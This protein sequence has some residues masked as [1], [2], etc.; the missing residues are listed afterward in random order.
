MKKSKIVIILISSII[1]LLC[2]IF[3]ILSM[4]GTNEDLLERTA[5]I[6]M[7]D[8]DISS[9]I[10]GRIEWIN[11][12]EGDIIYEGQKLFKLT[13]R[14]ISAKVEQA[15][16]AV[17]SAQAQ[18]SM[19]NNGARPEQI[20]MA[21][22]NYIAA[23]SQYDLAKKTYDRMKKLHDD[24]LI[25]DQDLDVIA[26]K[27]YAA[28]AQMDASSSQY[29]MAQKGSRTEE[30][31]MAQGQ[32]YRAK[33]SLEEA[34][35]YFDE[36]VVKSL[37]NGI[38]YKRYVDKGELVATGYPVLSVI[39]TNDV[40]AEL[41]LPAKELESIKIG[42][43]LDG[44][45]YGLGTTE[46]FKVVSFAQMGEYSNWRSTNEKATFDTHSFTVKLKPLNKSIPS[47]RPGM[48]VSFKIKII[49]R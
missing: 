44:R 39:D 9:K 20:E 34:K 36:S 7:R 48:S 25:S 32:F 38:V 26:Q 35:S 45:I 5:T 4:N 3:T 43:V 10:P 21:E 27:L 17:E 24:K 12:D 31:Q 29:Q 28:S 8:Y 19:A 40:W 46:K 1:I 49:G 16:G 15:Q 22:K 30:K 33:Q 47:L 18:L 2:A 23:K 37:Y 11:V 13:D 14:E 6:E 42:D 41:N